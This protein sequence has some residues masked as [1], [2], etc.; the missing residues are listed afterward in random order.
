VFYCSWRQLIDR[1]QAPRRTESQ[2][3]R[4]ERDG[5]AI[6]TQPLATPCLV[7]SLVVQMMDAYSLDTASLYMRPEIHITKRN[8]P[9]YNMSRCD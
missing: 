9:L 7:R 8:M 1:D 2:P 6:I 5:S 4:A 3:Q